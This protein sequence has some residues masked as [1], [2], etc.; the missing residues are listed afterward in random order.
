MTKR[1][2]MFLCDCFYGVHF[3]L[4]NQQLTHRQRPVYNYPTGH[5]LACTS[6][7]LFPR[8]TDVCYSNNDKTT[9]LY[10]IYSSCSLLFAFLWPN[11]GIVWGAY[12]A[13]PETW[14]QA[15]VPLG[16]GL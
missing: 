10:N 9:H 14:R 12:R 13:Y 2:L 4:A 1:L 11:T 8:R 3:T 6:G 15:D 7:Q 16:R 5:E